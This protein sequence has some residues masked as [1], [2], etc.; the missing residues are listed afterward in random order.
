MRAWSALLLIVVT[1]TTSLAQE[2]GVG[3]TPHHSFLGG[4]VL[5]VV[6]SALGI[7]M[8]CVAFRVIDWI[9]PGDL[10][11]ELAEEKNLAL[12]VLTGA[13]VVGVCIIIAAAMLG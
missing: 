11:R 7:A 6:Y 1:A 5:T 2:A 10:G 8:A 4:I 12:A 9:T 3:V 13:F